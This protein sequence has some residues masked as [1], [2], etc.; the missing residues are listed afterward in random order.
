[1]FGSLAGLVGD[2]LKI[3]AAPVS[4]ALDVTRA[5]TKPMA[6][7]VQEIAQEVKTALHPEE[8]RPK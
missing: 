7:A 4:V 1:M 8:Q 2:T 5:V 3:A 6:D